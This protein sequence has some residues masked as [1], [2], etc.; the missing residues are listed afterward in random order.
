MDKRQEKMKRSVSEKSML[1][2]RHKKK[3]SGDDQSM[4]KNRFLVTVNV[5]GSAGP[6]R[7]VVKEDDLVSGVIQTALKTYAREGRLPVLG[8]EVNNFVLH[9]AAD[10]DALNPSEAIGSRG[11]RNFVLCKKQI[12]PQMT[13]ARSEMISHKRSGSWKAWFNKSFS[14][15]ILSH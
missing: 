8:T 5:L 4:N 6:I 2:Q 3:N 1:M 12:Q 7:F 13:E 10:S 14:F 11:G 15:K 9:A